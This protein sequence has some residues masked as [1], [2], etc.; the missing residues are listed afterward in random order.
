MCAL[1]YAA[2]GEEMVYSCALGGYRGTP[3][4]PGTATTPGTGDLFGKLSSE[5]L[6]LTVACMNENAEAMRASVSAAARGE[7]RWST[8][9]RT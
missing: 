9:P 8:W 3:W 4:D 7:Y 1:G 5:I 6:D 2:V